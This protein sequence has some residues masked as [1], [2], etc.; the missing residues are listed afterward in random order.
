MAKNALVTGASRGLGRAIAN[1]LSRNGFRVLL[2]SS[3]TTALNHVLKE[4]EGDGHKTI[5]ADFTSKNDLENL[6]SATQEFCGQDGLSVFF[7]AAAATVD[8]EGE[9]ELGITPDDRLGTHFAISSEAPIMLLKGLKET[10]SAAKPSHAITMGTDWNIDGVFGPPVF[11]AAKAATMEV[12]KHSRKEYLSAGCVLSVIV[13]GNI[14]T[15]D[16]EWAEPKWTIDDKLEDIQAELG[17]TRVPIASIVAAFD[18]IR[19]APISAVT[20]V[21]LIPS[22]PDYEP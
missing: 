1:H 13:A 5:V 3:D 15:Y 11:A 12:W 7:N 9:A 10:L 6:L 19:N 4:L 18:F 22:D 8:P 2:T 14:A 17:I 16:A 20:K 21:E